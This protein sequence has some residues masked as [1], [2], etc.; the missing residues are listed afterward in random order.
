MAL[1]QRQ[2]LWNPETS[3]T[4]GDRRRDRR[5]DRRR[6]RSERSSRRRSRR[7]SL[8]VYTSGN[9]S[10][11]R[12]PRQSPRVYTTGDRSARRSL[13]QS[14]RRSPCVYALLRSRRRQ[15]VAS[16]EPNGRKS[17]DTPCR[18]YCFYIRLH[19]LPEHDGIS[20][21]CANKMGFTLS[22]LCSSAR[23]EGKYCIPTSKQNDGLRPQLTRQTSLNLSIISAA[24]RRRHVSLHGTKDDKYCRW[25]WVHLRFPIIAQYPNLRMLRTTHNVYIIISTFSS[26]CDVW[27]SFSRSVNVWT[28]SILLAKERG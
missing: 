12:S 7:R 4:R 8:R 27:R 10:P 22:P 13:R 15:N 3:Y 1:I 14:R 19:P 26:S 28:L 11:R 24:N 17:A 2:S 18:L 25:V 20:K 6:N 16:V 23:T 9:R 21:G 5:L